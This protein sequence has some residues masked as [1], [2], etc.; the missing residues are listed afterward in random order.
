MSNENDAINLAA[1]LLNSD[2]Q[3]A[4]REE[5]LNKAA[6]AHVTVAQFLRAS[7]LLQAVNGAPGALQTAK[8]LMDED[9]DRI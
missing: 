4:D 7:L 3:Q 6:A 9:E 5:A 2:A 1:V 8:N